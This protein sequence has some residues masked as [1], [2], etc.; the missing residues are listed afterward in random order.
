MDLPYS[1]SFQASTAEAT[2]GAASSK[3]WSEARKAIS[4]VRLN[5][6]AAQPSPNSAKSSY[7]Y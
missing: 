6:E 1:N 7:T 2:P 5:F 4:G 3:L